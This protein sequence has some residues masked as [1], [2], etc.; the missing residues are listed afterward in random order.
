[1]RIINLDLCPLGELINS[2][3][4]YKTNIDKEVLAALSGEFIG[5]RI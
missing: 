1:M 3:D 4:S 5:I 2:R